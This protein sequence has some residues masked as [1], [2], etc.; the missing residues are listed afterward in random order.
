M[1]KFLETII[2]RSVVDNQNLFRFHAIFV[3]EYLKKFGSS[4]KKEIA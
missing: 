2:I 3:T 1:E 4:D